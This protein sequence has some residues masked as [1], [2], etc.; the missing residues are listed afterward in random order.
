MEND[1]SGYLNK[2]SNTICVGCIYY[3][4]SGPHTYKHN[5]IWQRVKDERFLFRT[6][7][8]PTSRG[9]NAVFTM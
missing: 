8:T 7:A 4:R 3:A 9:S 2:Y 5:L 6:R 1:Q